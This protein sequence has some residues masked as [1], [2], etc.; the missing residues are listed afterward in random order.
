MNTYSD[1]CLYVRKQILQD[2][3][4]IFNEYGNELILRLEGYNLLSNQ[5]NCLES[6]TAPGFIIE[7]FL[8]SKLEIFTTARSNN[9]PINQNN[10]II[11]KVPEVT[12]SSYDCF[13]N[14][15]NTLFMINIKAQKNGINNN[16]VAAINRLYIDYCTQTPEQEKAFLILKIPYSYGYSKAK[17]AGENGRCII[18]DSDSIEGYFLEEIDFSKGHKQDHRNWRTN[19]NLNSGR[20]QITK[21]ILKENRLNFNNISYGRTFNFIK[22]IF[23]KNK[24]Q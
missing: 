9:K 20:L 15:E 12:N 2:V 10:I 11:Q 23:L 3:K 24:R 6:S 14:F 13:C 21:S 4:N 1:K 19:T 5:N 17:P 18:I 22:T 16:A 7:E 8:T